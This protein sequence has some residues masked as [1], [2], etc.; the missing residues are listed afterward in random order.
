L[1]GT[2]EALHRVVVDEIG[3]QNKQLRPTREAGYAPLIARRASAYVLQDGDAM[4]A[5]DRRDVA[6]AIR[7]DQSRV[8]RT[9][10]GGIQH[11]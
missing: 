9:S 10:S 5:Q 1:G 7:P 3:K 8:H 11:K 2:P 6:E 4:A